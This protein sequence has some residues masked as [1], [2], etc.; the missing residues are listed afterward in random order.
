MAKIRL[1]SAQWTV[2]TS[3]A[4][5]IATRDLMDVL[6]TQLEKFRDS[7]LKNANRF[8]T[9]LPDGTDVYSG[10]IT[11]GMNHKKCPYVVL[12][13]PRLITNGTF[14]LFRTLFWL[15][16]NYSFSVI[17]SSEFANIFFKLKDSLPEGWR[18]RVGGKEIWSNDPQDYLP[19][20]E[21]KATKGNWRVARFFDYDEFP[22]WES[23][24]RSSIEQIIE[25]L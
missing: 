4:Y 14:L 20:Q 15:G 9:I 25:A 19:I 17:G 18:A 1:N 22:R 24:V 8:K 2:L 10:R 13:Y 7:L 12:D 3:P 21:I 6:H 5:H 16:H 11:R 23:L